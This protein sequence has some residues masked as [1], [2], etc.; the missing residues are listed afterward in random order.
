MPQIGDLPGFSCV[1]VIT[2]LQEFLFCVSWKGRTILC[3][4]CSTHLSSI[5]ICISGFKH[6]LEILLF[7]EL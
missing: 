5:C 7:K 4:M 1:L 3:Y 6:I 2:A